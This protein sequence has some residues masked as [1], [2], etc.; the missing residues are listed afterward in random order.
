MVARGLRK[1]IALGPDRVRIGAIVLLVLFSW[2]F[3]IDAFSSIVPIVGIVQLLLAYLITFNVVK[4][5]QD[6]ERI[7]WGWLCA[8]A[9]SSALIVSA[10][11]RGEVLL[12]DIGESYQSQF[13]ELTLSNVSFLFRAT[14]FVAGVVFPLAAA[15][16]ATAVSLLFPRRGGWHRQLVLGSFVMID[17]L[18]MGVLSNK[19]AMFATSGATALMLVWVYRSKFGFARVSAALAVIFGVL[20][21]GYL[22]IRE[23]MSAGQFLLFFA[24]FGEGASFWERT[25]VWRGVGDYLITSPH[26][27]YL[28][29]GPDVSIRRMDHPL[30]QRLFA[31]GGRQQ[32]AVDSGFLYVVLNY[33]LFVLLLGLGMTIGA[34]RYLTRA[35]LRN[36]DPLALSL[37]LS[38]TVWLIMEISQQH[39]V[40]KPALMI[41]QV[42][43]LVHVARSRSG[44]F[45]AANFGNAAN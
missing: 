23:V 24:R 40:S 11:S 34:W 21:L 44:N 30:F 45:F 29:L 39:G 19:T 22:L 28:G 27:L 35:L 32:G 9:L 41:V 16:V 15:T 36:I 1:P 6:A 31:G 8:V 37:W 42:I 4:D 13:R 43:A 33:G 10:Y 18:A 26:A 3:S 5:K 12:L 2:A 25:A 20:F 14:F 7:M 38:I 17:L